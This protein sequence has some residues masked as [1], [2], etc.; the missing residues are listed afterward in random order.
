[1]PHDYEEY[2]EAALGTSVSFFR[3][4]HFAYHMT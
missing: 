2:E 1:M 3:L 4:L